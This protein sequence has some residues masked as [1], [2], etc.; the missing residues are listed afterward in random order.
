MQIELGL[1][2]SFR[3]LSRNDAL[4]SRKAVQSRN[5]VI[6]SDAQPIS[7]MHP[8]QWISNAKT[9]FKCFRPQ[10]ADVQCLSNLSLA[11]FYLATVR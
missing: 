6:L 10:I 11:S 9:V 5:W 1:A 4:H 3:L 7:M 2:W 8:V